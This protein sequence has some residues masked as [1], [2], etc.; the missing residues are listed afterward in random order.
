VFGKWYTTW[1]WFKPRLETAYDGKYPNGYHI[2]LDDEHISETYIT[3]KVRVEYRGIVAR[4]YEYS[5]AGEKIPTIV[6]RKMRVVDILTLPDR[7][8]EVALYHKSKYAGYKMQVVSD[9]MT[10]S[11]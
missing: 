2:W 8:V 10:Y 3:A 7:L 6:A 1:W 9:F 5:N 4:G 11:P